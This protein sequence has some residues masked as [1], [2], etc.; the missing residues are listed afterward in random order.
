MIF[1][2]QYLIL[3]RKFLKYINAY[4]CFIVHR[5]FVI[6]NS[7][8][9]CTLDVIY[10]AHIQVYGIK[11]IKFIFQKLISAQGGEVCME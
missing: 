1:T 6:V 5:L 8:L 4:E 2:L 9:Y 10:L 7:L 3:Q 11:I